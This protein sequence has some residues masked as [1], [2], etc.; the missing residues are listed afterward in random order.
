MRSL[1]S[2]LLFFL[3]A[4][5][6]ACEEPT[7]LK[8]NGDEDLDG[9]T[10]GDEEILGTDPYIADSDGDGM[11]D[12]EEIEAGTNPLYKYSHL[13]EG[14]YRV[15]YCNVKPVPTGPTLEQ[16]DPTVG[17][18]F[19]WYSLQEGDVPFNTQF[20]DQNGEVVDLYSFCG[21]QVMV[22]AGAGW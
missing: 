21:T 5:A 11:S 20:I 7:G 4:S 1:I 9:L 16:K 14:D 13:Y 8:P 19:T 22:L 2:I 18:N 12:L 6:P 10:N 15:G 17:P 3:L